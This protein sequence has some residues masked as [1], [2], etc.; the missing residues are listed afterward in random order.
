MNRGMEVVVIR[1]PIIMLVSVILI[2]GL[3][4]I[5]PVIFQEG[6]PVPILKGI[7]KLSTSD[8]KIIQI[9][10]N[11]QR[12]LTKTSTG[13]TG[14]IDL[15]NKEGWEF[16]EQMGAGYIFSKAGDRLVIVSVQY[17]GKYRIWNLTFPA[18]VHHP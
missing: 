12:Y 6:N 5:S 3:I 11:P 16:V 2:L 4:K 7:V 14:L 8:D 9:S 10:E 18:I 13:D 15:M 1:K 17:T